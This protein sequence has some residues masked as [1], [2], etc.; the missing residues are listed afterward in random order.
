MLDG[1]P[2]GRNPD[3]KSAA[4]SIELYD[5]E[6]APRSSWTSAESVGVWGCWKGWFLKSFLDLD[7]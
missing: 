1:T 6:E 3:E 2:L 4:V 5:L 7:V